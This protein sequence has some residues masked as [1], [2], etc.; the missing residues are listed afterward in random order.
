MFATNI[1]KFQKQKNMNVWKPL[2]GKCDIQKDF[3]E[4]T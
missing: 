3:P 1:N 4:E 2:L